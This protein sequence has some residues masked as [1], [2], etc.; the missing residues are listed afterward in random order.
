MTRGNNR[1]AVFKSPEDYHYYL[2]LISRFKQE[3]PFDLYHYCLIPNHTHM[4]IR[5]QNAKD[6]SLFIKKINLAY[7]QHYKQ[8]Y[9]WV[10]HLWQ[11]RYKS[12]PVG[13]DEYFI[14][15]GKYIEL[16][17][18]RAKLITEPK[19]YPYSSYNFYAY[20]K[21]NNLI[22][23]DIFYSELGETE[24]E[25]QEKYR[26]LVIDKIV[27]KSYQKDVWGADK[28][29][30]HEGRKIRYNWSKK[31]SENVAERSHEKTE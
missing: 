29:R 30:Y 25:R 4:L 8:S 21:N 11:G 17:P 13:K 26:E 24:I 15:C 18:I 16:N 20:G 27:E 28:Q 2:E 10:G 22:T 3:L 12:Q 23:E 6:F 19:N 7:F 1:N 9:D 14:Q 31:R 5:T